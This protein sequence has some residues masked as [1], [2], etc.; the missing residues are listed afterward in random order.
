LTFKRN[1]QQKPFAACRGCAQPGCSLRNPQT[2]EGGRCLHFIDSSIQNVAVSATTLLRKRLDTM[3]SDASYA[4][5]L[6]LNLITTVNLPVDV[7]VDL[8]ADGSVLQTIQE[9]RA[10]YEQKTKERWN[11]LMTKE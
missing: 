11:K 8:L 10:W 7:Q 6:V 4:P 2:D 9:V 3:N 5:G 1:R